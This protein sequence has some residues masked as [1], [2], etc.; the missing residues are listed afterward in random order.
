MGTKAK[1]PE[2]REKLLRFDEH[3]RRYNVK[4]ILDQR[5]TSL[6]QRSEGSKHH[7]STAKGKPYLTKL[8]F[9]AWYEETKADFDELYGAWVQAGFPISLSPSVD[10]IDSKVGYVEGNMQWL[11]LEDNMKKSNK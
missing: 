1:T 3:R 11:T 5:Y 7:P 10:R 9:M 6:K 2:Q 4:R 8:E